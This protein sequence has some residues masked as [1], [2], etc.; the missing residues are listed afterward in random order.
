MRKTII[1]IT[2]ALVLSVALNVVLAH[3]V[4]SLTE[5]LGVR[6]GD[7]LLQVG[8]TAPPITANRLDGQQEV[9]SY[10][11]TVH[12][13]VLYIF[14]PPCTWCARNMD[15]FKALLGKE[16]GEYRFIALS[17]SEDT[18]ADYV[19]KND[20]KLPVYTRLS[21]ET[22]RTYKLGG[23]PQTIVVSSEGKVLKDW[24]GAYVGDQKSQVEAFFHVSLPGLRELPKVEAAKEKGKT[25]TTGQLKEQSEIRRK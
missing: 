11:A 7:H 4:R 13:T 22:L 8:A 17:L 23:T 3:K 21:S 9:I 19:A 6:V 16:S 15:N 12:P 25:G 10:G 5:A 18:L 24:A 20:L 14:T 1:S 2:V